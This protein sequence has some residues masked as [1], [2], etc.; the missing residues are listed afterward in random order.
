MN[1][2]IDYFFQEIL[3]SGKDRNIQEHQKEA[4]LRKS[5][6]FSNVEKLKEYM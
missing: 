6:L 5:C 2:R 3:Q 4:D 1:W